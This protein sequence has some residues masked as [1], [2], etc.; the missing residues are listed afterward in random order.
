MNNPMK[1]FIQENKVDKDN[2]FVVLKFDFPISK[3][4]GEID[5]LS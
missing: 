2:T 5:E 4:E 1:C 3:L